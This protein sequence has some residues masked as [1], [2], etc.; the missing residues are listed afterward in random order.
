MLALAALAALLCV[1]AVSGPAIAA[2]APEDP[3]GDTPQS[4]VEALE[5]VAQGYYDVQAVLASSRQREKE[6]KA[7]LDV[8]QAGLDRI[9]GKIG[10]VASAR[11]KG[12]SVG[13]INGLIDGQVAT[14]DL[15]GGAAVSEY[16]LWRDDSYIREFRVI[17]QD[18]EEQQRLLTAELEIQSKQIQLLDQQ[19]REAEKALAAVGGLPTAGLEGPARPAQPAPRNSGGGFSAER[20][21]LNDPTTGGCLTARTYHMLIEARFADFT[22]FVSCYRSGTFGEHPRGRACDFSV[23]T[24]GGFQARVASGEAREYGNNLAR[25]AVG[26]ASALGVLYVIW[27]R[28]IWTPATGWHWYSGSGGDP[29]SD[30]TN[31]VHIS[32]R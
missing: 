1:L 17:K 22:R 8:A 15:L 9:A 14:G 10:R 30:H 13:L 7:S 23:Y 12:G 20:C 2:P 19:K 24:S 6:I 4:L 26:N 11:F 32:M 21:S 3:D 28:Q 5:Q 25:W 27:Y 31:H 29:A 18:A 16:L